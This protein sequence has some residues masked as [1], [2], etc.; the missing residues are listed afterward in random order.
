MEK[1]TTRK[2]D[3]RCVRETSRVV[4]LVSTI[5]QVVASERGAAQTLL[6]ELLHRVIAVRLLQRIKV[7]GV[8]RCAIEGSVRIVVPADSRDVMNELS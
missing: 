3:V 6:R 7:K 8:G 2:P 4:H 1:R 5:P